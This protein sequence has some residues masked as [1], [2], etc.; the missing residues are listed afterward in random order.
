MKITVFCRAID[1]MAGGV[2]RMASALMNEMTARGHEVSLVTLDHER[3]KSYYPLDERIEWHKVAIGNPA[4]KATIR[5]MLQR[6]L[7]VR[8]IVNAIKPDIMIGFQDGAY[9]SNRLYTIGMGYPIILAERNAP[10]RY[11]HIR[12]GKYRKLIYQTF[13]FARRIT[14]QCESYRKH[15]PAYLRPRIITIPNPV[16]PAEPRYLEK[17]KERKVLLSV[18][19]LEY[20]KNYGVLIEAFALIAQSHPDW[21]LRIVGEGTDRDKLQHLIEQKN[22]TGRVEMPGTNDL[23]AEEY[24]RASLFCLPSRFEGFPNAL[25]EA[26][27]HG[28]PCVGFAEC[29]GVSDLIEHGKN[30]R[31]AAG[32]SNPE[33]LAKELDVLMR[34]PDLL[35]KTGKLAMNSVKCYN[36]GH[37]YDLWE[38]TFIEAKAR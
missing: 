36:P 18:G 30:G 9:L 4:R 21:V 26:M 2:E 5:E 11:D 29:A 23:I 20:Q 10:T 3:A 31:L 17:K 1:N 35:T 15:Y 14:I 19:R 8:A 32:N 33:H 28:L 27:A 24:A 37:I 6:A 25:A 7:R 38:R 22:L 34:D 12:S 13:R 16:F